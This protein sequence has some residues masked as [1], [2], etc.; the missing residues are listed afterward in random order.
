MKRFYTRAEAV[1]DGSSWTVRLDGKPVRTPAR[2]P[3]DLPTA[4]LAAAIAAEWEAQGE[5]VKPATM[6]LTGLAFAAIDRVALDPAAF[7][8]SLAAYA[9]TELLC[10]RADGPADL[11]ARQ[12]AEWDPLLAWARAR[13]DIGFFVTA[14]IVHAAQPPATLARI[15]AAYA[16]LD[17]FRL[18]SLHP[19]VT[20][21]GSAVIGL[22]VAEGRMDAAAAY[23]AGQLDELWQAEQWGHDPLAAAALASRRAALEDAVR[24]LDLLDQGDYRAED[25]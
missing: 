14:G 19:V 22:A 23:A 18:A 25:A 6:P 7:A 13:F 12:R 4:A 1:A 10:Y 20:I 11:V 9:E 17:P 16:A 8:A 24:L 15:R 21:T 2:V 3:L 5:T